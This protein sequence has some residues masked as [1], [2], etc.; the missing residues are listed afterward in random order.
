VY[1]YSISPSVFVMKGLGGFDTAATVE[2]LDWQ[3]QS[4]RLVECE[5]EALGNR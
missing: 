3:A 4:S 2:Q 1:A 5:R